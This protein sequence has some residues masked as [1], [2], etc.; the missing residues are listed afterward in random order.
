MEL[1]DRIEKVKPFFVS[2]NVV[3][4]E[5]AAY[6]VVKFPSEWTIPDQSAMKANFKVEIAPM[7]N[8]ICFVTEIKNGAE[9]IF[10]ALDYVI[11]FNK[12]VQE[13]KGLLLEKIKELQNLFATETL[14]RLKTLQFTF[15]P[16]KKS[17]KKTVSKKQG[18][19]VEPVASADSSN[20]EKKEADAPP[21]EAQADNSLMSF[22]KNI[23]SE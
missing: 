7:Q 3:A 9:C 5:A 16:Q 4:E 22:A 13:R 17:G 14:D 11:D 18:T 21:E 8:G 19:A 15:A 20:L 2:F 12:K 23:A 10:D 1:N 6:A